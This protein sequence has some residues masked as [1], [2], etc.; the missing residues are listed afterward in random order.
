MKIL[1]ILSHISFNN[2]NGIKKQ[3]EIWA[4]ELINRG[5]E[6]IKFNEWNNIELKN[7]DLIHIFGASINIYN[8]IE[9][10]KKYNIPIIV[11]PIIDSYMSIRK[12]KLLSIIGLPKFKIFTNFQILRYIKPYIAKILV[13]SEH[14]SKYIH[15][16]LNYPKSKISLLRLPSRLFAQNKNLD[17][18]KKENFCLHVSLFT[19]ERKNVWRLMQSAV[20][21]NFKLIIVGDYIEN[22]ISKKYFD[23]IQQH[24]NIKILGPVSEEELISLYKNAKVFALPSINEGVGFTALE[25]ANYGCNIV[26]TNIG[27]PKEYYGQ[28]AYLVD[29][30]DMDSIGQAIKRAMDDPINNELVK[31]VRENYNLKTNINNLINIYNEITKTKDLKGKI[32][33]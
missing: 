5:Y 14:E 24:D 8:Y 6:V 23:F 13:R 31:M 15:D 7:I 17:D 27:G 10:L 29:P 26:I 3:A 2:T 28:Y 32:L 9:N 25:A 30:F 21:Y 33:N 19:Q 22:D 18:F 12:Y 20:K 1:Y 16:A 4:N 11:S